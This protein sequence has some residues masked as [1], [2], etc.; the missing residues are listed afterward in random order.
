MFTRS[1]VI[2]LT[3]THTNRRRWKHPTLFATLRRWVTTAT[4]NDFSDFSA[5]TAVFL[6]MISAFCEMSPQRAVSCCRHG[7]TSRQ[8]VRRVLGGVNYHWTRWS[9]TRCMGQRQIVLRSTQSP[10][11][12]S[13]HTGRECQQVKCG[14]GQMLPLL[15]RKIR[16]M[17]S[18]TDVISSK[19][20]AM[21]TLATFNLPAR[22]LINHLDRRISNSYDKAT[23]TPIFSGIFSDGVMF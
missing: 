16:F 3:N 5:T 22:Q 9:H 6:E 8:R 15:A 7:S 21:K 19:Q 2:V 1:E 23:K 4:A 13:N 14:E 18:Q 11:H 12:W 17:S 10:V 20:T